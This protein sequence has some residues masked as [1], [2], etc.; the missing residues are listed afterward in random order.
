YFAESAFSLA[1]LRCRG[2]PSGV[3]GDQWPYQPL[4]PPSSARA[5]GAGIVKKFQTSAPVAALY[6]RTN[7]RIPYSAPDE[8][9]ITLSSMMRGAI[10]SVYPSAGSAMVVTHF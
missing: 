7:P 9:M 5:S 2:V 6:A 1:M 3:V 8:P 10:V 4:I